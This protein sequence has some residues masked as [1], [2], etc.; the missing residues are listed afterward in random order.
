MRNLVRPRLAP[1]VVAMA[2]VVGLLAAIELFLSPSIFR[3]EV[4]GRFLVERLG[5]H[6]FVTYSV[7]N[8]PPT[9]A[10][11]VVLFG[12]SG[13]RCLVGL[14][15]VG[16]RLEEALGRNVR[17]LNLTSSLQSLTE[18]LHILDN[19]DLAPGSLIVVA[20]NPNRLSPT[21]ERTVTEFTT[22]SKF[23]PRAA[24]LETLLR[25]H[26]SLPPT[27]PKLIRLSFLMREV[28]QLSE[29]KPRVMALVRD[30][31]GGRATWHSIR[32]QVHNLFALEPYLQRRNA[33]PRPLPSPEFKI[34]EAR[35]VFGGLAP[36]FLA[37]RAYAA[38]LTRRL[39][40]A[41]K[42]KG[43]R[44]IFVDMPLDPVPFRVTPFPWDE[45]DA[46]IAEL[47]RDGQTFIDM[48]TLK[49]VS[50]EWFDDIFHIVPAYQ[51]SFTP[52]FVDTVRR[53]MPSGT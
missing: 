31:L 45:Y 51:Q 20:V 16:E 1:V 50:T 2:L 14:D 7:V 41:A 19:L 4:L 8:A 12:G 29:L 15:E 53:H 26:E 38:D 6:G 11:S 47:L 18:D 46:F 32:T 23:L 25:D 52:H 37:N 48:K 42:L 28:I 33:I 43:A 39:V 40:E 49:G 44:V 34:R 10:P 9:D 13:A 17:F 24:A 3:E 22:F 21:I 30:V 5:D 27:P 36:R 35:R